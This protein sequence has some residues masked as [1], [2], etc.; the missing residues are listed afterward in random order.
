[1]VKNG[2]IHDSELEEDP[3][4]ETRSAVSKVAGL[5]RGRYDVDEDSD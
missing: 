5:T 2:I 4:S 3:R 1:M